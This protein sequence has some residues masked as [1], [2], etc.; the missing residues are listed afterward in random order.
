[1]CIRDRIIRL[2]EILDSSLS[3][4]EKHDELRRVERVRRIVRARVSDVSTLS[5]PSPP[6]QL[7]K[8]SSVILTEEGRGRI[9]QLEIQNELLMVLLDGQVVATIPDIIT[10]LH[11]EDASVANL[12][13]L[14]VGNTLDIVMIRAYDP[15]YSEPGLALSGPDAVHSWR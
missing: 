11:P 14:W 1:M 12:E 7:D 6:G 8:P 5:R 9:V 4:A 3:V 2:G 10:L 15:W 13:D